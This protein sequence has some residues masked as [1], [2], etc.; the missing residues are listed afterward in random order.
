MVEANNNRSDRKPLGRNPGDIWVVFAWF[1]LVN[2]IVE[3]MARLLKQQLGLG[4]GVSASIIWVAPLVYLL[5]F[6]LLAMILV[7]MSRLSPRRITVGVAV[8]LFSAVALL[9]WLYIGLEEY[10]AKSALVIL[11]AGGAMSFVRWVRP[12][13]D[14]SLAFWRNSL[15]YLAGSVA[16]AAL[17]IPGGSWVWEQILTSRLG[18]VAEES[19]NVLMIVVDTLR[20]D[21]VSAYGYARPT[22]PFLDRLAENGVLFEN[23]FSTSPWSLPSHVSLVTGT[24]FSSHGV[25]WINH[26]AL[27]DS[28]LPTVAERLHAF[29]YRTGAFSANT[30]WVTHERIGRGFVHFDDYFGS[31]EDGIFR[32]MYGAAVN[33]FVLNRLGFENVKGRRHAQ[34]VNRSLLKWIDRDSRRPFFAMVNYIDAHD[35]YLPPQPYRSMFTSSPSPGGIINAFVG[36][37][38]PNLTPQQ[39]DD[40]IAAYDGAIAFVDASLKQLSEELLRRRLEN[41]IVIVTSDHGEGFGEHGLLLH[42]H[43]L[44]QEQLRVPLIFSWPGMIPPGKRV[45]QV[46]TNAGLAATVM[47]LV[48]A[49][50]E[51]PFPIPSLADAWSKEADANA[52][53]SA[54]AECEKQSWLPKSSPAFTGSLE[55]L[56]TPRLHYI[57]HQSLAP[58]LFD[59]RRDLTEIH[60]LFHLPEYESQRDNL[61]MRLQSELHK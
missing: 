24:Y 38:E 40:E 25:G 17:A 7:G 44:Y 22:T 60:D 16:C 48:G 5:A 37:A 4:S 27:R 14:S 53:A 39:L 23:A 41:T 52:E 21:H 54:I 46:V 59:W 9:D 15:P 12:R 47:E 61:K 3:G 55:C 31:L 58:Q 28:N 42:G 29:G 19:P 34:D 1:S 57:E 10:V 32:T 2:G 49:R 36:R 6:S 43:S 51:R 8:F 30:F 26:T 35:P 11:A 45:P 50:N 18:P 20:A 13:I 33:K 56:I